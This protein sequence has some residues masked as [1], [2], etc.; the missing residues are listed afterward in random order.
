MGEGATIRACFCHCP[1]QQK[2][3]DLCAEMCG[4]LNTSVLCNSVADGQ[5]L[6]NFFQDFQKFES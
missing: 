6:K 4:Q 2:K 1:D 3:G 5:I